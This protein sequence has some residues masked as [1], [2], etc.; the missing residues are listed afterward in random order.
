MTVREPPA[1]IEPEPEGELRKPSYDTSI[2]EYL[3]LRGA[4]V[5]PRA[6]A[7]KRRRSQNLPV[8]SAR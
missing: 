6:E 1:E 3:H 5:A 2:T 8:V 4:D 7:A